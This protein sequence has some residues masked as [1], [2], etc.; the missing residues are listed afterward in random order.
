[1]SL[2]AEPKIGKFIAITIEYENTGHE[3]ALNFD[4][5]IIPH[6][7]TDAEAAADDLRTVF[8][9]CKAMPDSDRGSVVFPGLAGRIERPDYGTVIPDG[10]IDAAVEKGQ[11]TLDISGC[12]TYQ[13]FGTVH[14]TS[15][16]YW[17]RKGATDF[18]NLRVCGG[19][20]NSAD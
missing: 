13:T 19:A 20:H 11:S 4:F 2:S 7:K 3:P 16:C 8:D 9:T 5:I 18:R 1:M 17:Y 6:V 12:F 15:F 10:L 14:H